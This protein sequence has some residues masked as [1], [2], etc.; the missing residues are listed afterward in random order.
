MA[1]T[2]GM[3]SRDRGDSARRAPARTIVDP[4]TGQAPT[5]SRPHHAPIANGPPRAQSNEPARG[6]HQRSSSWDGMGRVFTPPAARQ[7][8]SRSPSPSTVNRMTEEQRTACLK[9]IVR[10]RNSPSPGTRAQVKYKGRK[11]SSPVTIVSSPVM[12]GK[13]SPSRSPG[14]EMSRYSI[15]SSSPRSSA[16][17]KQL[18]R[19]LD[20]FCDELAEINQL[21]E[22]INENLGA[23]QICA[24]TTDAKGIRDAT[25]GNKP[26]DLKQMA[27]PP[28][29]RFRSPKHHKL[30]VDPPSGVVRPVAFDRPTSH[31]AVQF[32]ASAPPVARPTFTAEGQRSAFFRALSRP[33][34]AALFSAAR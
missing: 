31:P 7:P 3:V 17:K 29:E 8:L 2:Q 22:K 5:I 19:E 16:A 4:R 14:D 15:L 20:E 9:G 13:Q 28:Q 10:T 21:E 34:L 12:I 11:P 33:S 24:E 18:E 6:S 26:G 25:G 27:T 32:V 1:V 30:E 23:L